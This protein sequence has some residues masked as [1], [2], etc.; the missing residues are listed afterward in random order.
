MPRLQLSCLLRCGQ[1]IA[2]SNRFE[3]NGQSKTIV[4]N[5]LHKRR[6]ERLSLSLN[7]TDLAS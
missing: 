7:A 2:S 1:S 6:L 3:T 5:R 4:L